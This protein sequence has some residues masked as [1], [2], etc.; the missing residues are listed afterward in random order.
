M[1]GETDELK[2]QAA[3][4]NSSCFLL[5]YVINRR[6]I[7]PKLGRMQIV[8]L[9][10]TRIFLDTKQVNPNLQQSII[11]RFE[12][13]RDRDLPNIPDQIGKDYR[14]ALDTEILLALGFAKERIP[15][16]IDDMYNAL[17]NRFFLN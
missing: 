17:R 15:A 13:F 12:L 10:N 8:D 4:I 5:L 3:W 16:L 6:E 14:I 1:K 2:L 11:D 9:M 7:G